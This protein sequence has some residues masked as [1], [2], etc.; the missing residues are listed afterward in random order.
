MDKTT[1]MGDKFGQKGF[2][3]KKVTTNQKYSQA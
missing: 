3:Q 1:S 2:T